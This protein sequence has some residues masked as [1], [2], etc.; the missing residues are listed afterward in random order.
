[1]SVDN[2]K[3]PTAM[4]ELLAGVMV[5]K[6]LYD[7]VQL[8]EISGKEEDILAEENASASDKITRVLA[9]CIISLESSVPD[10]KPITDNNHLKAIV[11]N[12]AMGD[13]IFLFIRLRVLSLDQ[14]FVMD[15]Q[16]PSDE[17]VPFKATVDLNT[18][19]LKKLEDKN[20]RTM[21]VPLTDGGEV[22]LKLATGHDEGLLSTIKNS[23]TRLTSGMM[24][25]IESLNGKPAS[26]EDVQ[27]LSLR[28]RNTIRTA[29]QKWDVG[30]DTTI[31]ATDPLD[32][33]DFDTD[34]QLM[35]ASFFFPSE[36]LVD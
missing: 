32:G 20:I 30:V 27:K 21:T 23:K 3:S 10:T 4:E 11:K 6:I 19:E 22:V 33:K 12:L 25:R 31:T 2:I 34:L 28:N 26:I 1:M 13:R 29:T 15:L 24:I 16:C 18:L 7:K 36:I 35:Q 9:N 8:T 5:D 14:N 17:K